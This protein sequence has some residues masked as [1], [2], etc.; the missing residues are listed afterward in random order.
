MLND[1]PAVIRKMNVDACEL[2]PSVAGSLL[3]KR[4]NA[5]GLRLLLTIGEMLTGPVVEEFGGSGERPSMLWGMYGPTE[6]AI[7]CTVQPAFAHDSTV[8]NIGVPLDTVSAFILRIPGRDNSNWAFEVLPRGEVG[9]LAIGGHQLA[10]GYLNRPD[11]TSSAFI[12]TPFGH[13]YRTGDKARMN[14]DGT[15]E[16]LGRIADGQVKLRGQRIELG[17]IEHAA[18]RTPGCHNAVAAVIEG[19]LV[20]FCAVDGTGDMASAIRESCRE[21]LPGFMVPGD[22]VVLSSFPRLPSGKID[23]KRLVA[24]YQAGASEV[25]QRTT[26]RDALE[27]QLC[28]LAGACLGAKVHP[29]QDLHRAGLDSLSAIKFASLLRKAG[30]EIGAIDVLGARTVSAL[31]S[32]LS[33]PMEAG[34]LTS[35]PGLVDSGWLNI[36]GVLEKHPMLSHLTEH[37]ESI[38]PCTPLQTSMLAE[39]MADPRAYCNWVELGFPSAYTESSIR[40]WFV[41]LAQANEILRTGFVH[42]EGKFLQVIFRTFNESRLSMTDAL[43]KEFEMR[44]D[45]DFLR[46]FRVQISSSPHGAET[47]VLVQLHHAVYDGWSMDLMLADLATTARGEQPKARAQFRAIS[48]YHQSAAFSDSC[49]AAREFWAGNLLDFQPPAFPVWNAEVPATSAVLSSSIFLDVDPQGLK[50][51]LQ[52]VDCTPQT[53]FQAA[54]A[55]LWSSAAGSE[56]VVIGSVTS[57]RT[58]PVTKIEDIIGPCIATVPIRTDLS[59]VRT[60]RD[61]LVSVHAANRAALPHSVLPLSEIKRVAGLHAG[62]SVYDVLFVYQ[63]SLPSRKRDPY[64]FRKVASQDHLETKLLVEVEPRAKDFDCRFTYHSDAFPVAQV[65]IF[66]EL[67]RA[68]IL[69]ILDNVDLEISSLRK[70]FPEHLLSVYNPNPRSFTGV[71]DLAYAV[72]RSAASFP[73]KDAVCFADRISDGV[74]KAITIT[75]AE[76]NTTADRIAWHLV[77]RG[78]REAGVVSIIMEKSVRFYA[79]VLA[80]LKAG[81]AYLP[82]LP[83]TPVARIDTIL[84]QTGCDLCL[85]DAATRDKLEGR[86]PCNFM[87]IESLDL[88]ST[89]ALSVKAKPDPGRLAYIIY[90]SGSTG[91]PKGVCVTQLNIMSNLD[92]LS[93]VYPVKEN[94]RLLQSCSQAF[95]VSV[96]EIFFAWTRGICLCSAIND[97]LF[98]N[99]ERSI[100]KLNITHLSMTPTVAS[101]VDPEKVPQVEFLVTAGEAMTEVVAKAWGEKLYQGYGPSE[102]TNICSVKKMGPNQVI[103]HLG[104]SFENTSTVVLAKDGLEIVPLGCLG[105]LCF[106]GDQVARGYLDMDDRTSAKFIN[107]STLGRIYRSGDLG[108]MLP[109]GSMVIAGRMDEQIK[110][111]GQR[112]ELNEITE[113]IRHSSAT[114]A[115][116]ATLFLREEETP[117]QDLIVAFLVPKQRE[118]TH[119]QV[120]DV[121][122]ELRG[123]IQSLYH[124]LSSQLPAYM[125]PSATIPISVLPTT[126]SGKLDR[127]RLQQTFRGLQKDFLASV[128]YGARLVT[129]EGQWSGDEI[130]VAEAVACALK[131]GREDVRRW[132]PLAALGLDSIS[133]IQVSKQLQSKLGK[134]IPISLILQNASVARMAKVLSDVDTPM[135]PQEEAPDLLPKELVGE[136]SKRLKRQGKQFSRILPCTPLQEAMLAASAGKGHKGQYLNR[137]LF[138]VNGDL[139]KLKA[140]WNA[141]CARHGGLR[142][143]FLATDDA[144]WPILQV[145]LDQ[146]QPFWHE[147][148]ASGLAIEDCISEH[149]HVVPDALEIMEPAISLATIAG[150]DNIYLSFVCHHALYDG[151]AIERL[152]Y[153]VEQHYSGSALP[154]APVYDHFLRESQKLP[155]STDGFWRQHLAGYEPK[156]VVHLSSDSSAARTCALTCELDIPLSRVKTTLRE[157]GV[158]LLALTQSAWAIALSCVFR[159]SDICFGNVVNGRSLPIEGSHELVAPCFNTIPIRIGLPRGH[160]NVDL[161]KA[162]Q[163]L[164]TELMQYQFTPLKR[165]QSQFSQHGAWRLFDTLLL[166]QQSPRPLDRAI[167]TVE[168]DEGEMDV[169][170]VCEVTP[171][172]HRDSVTVKLHTMESQPL[173]HGIVEL[174]FDLF[175]CAMRDCLQFPASHIASHDI[176]QGLAERLSRIQL[177]PPQSAVTKHQSNSTTESWTTTESSVRTVL[178]TLS[179]SNDERIRRNTTIYQLGLDSISAVQIASMLRQLGYQVVA[180]DVIDHPTCESLARYMDARLPGRRHTATCDLREFQAEVESQISA[181]HVSMDH[182]EAV[183]PCTP[184]QSSMM[185]QF[186]KSGGR[187]YFNYVS[188][189]LDESIST[190]KLVEA[191]QAVCLGHP[192][193]RTGIVSVEHNDWPFAMVQ[194]HSHMF[195]PT[196][197]SIPSE[198]AAT[199]DLETWRLRASRA[200]TNEPHKRLWS[201]AIVEAAGG[202]AMHLAIHHA[203][204]DAHSLQL[205]LEDLSKAVTG[206]QISRPIRMES[207]VADILDQISAATKSSGEFWK[208][209]ADK[210]VINGFPVMTPLRQASRDILTECIASSTPLTALEEAAARSGCTLQAV[211]QAAWTRILSAYLGEPSVVFGVVLSGRNTEETRSAVFPCITT[212]PVI[213]ANSSS[214]RS[215]LTHMLQYNAE[216]F[217][218]QHQPLTRVQQWLGCPDSRLFDTLLVYQKLDLDTPERR[219]WRIVD[220][221]ASVDYPV[222][223]EIEPSPGGRLRYSVTFFSDV[224]PKEQAGMLLGQFDAA[225]RHLALEPDGQEEDIFQHSPDLF[226]VLPPEAPEIPTIVEFLHDFVQLQAL[227]TPDATALQF[228]ERFDG[229]VPVGRTWTYRELDD[230]G[231]RVAQ[232]LLPHVK[233]GDIVAVCF[234][235]CPEA[236]F[237]ILGV[238]KAGCAFVALDPGAPRS[239]NEF[240]VDDSGALVLLTSTRNDV[241]ELAI[242]VPV[243]RVGEDSLTGVSA[244]R[245]DTRRDLRP[246]DVCYCLYTSGTTG[247]PKGCEITHENAVQ[248]MLAFQHIFEGRWQEDSRW[249]QFASLHFDVSVLEQYW[250]WSVGITLVAAPR[251]LILEDLAGTIFR[252]E[253][254]H[255]D[256]TPSLARLLHPD[257]VPSL[258]KGVFIT[259][260]EALK[261][262]ILDVW[263]SKGVIYNFYGPT[264][265]TIG[266]TVY[267]RVPATGRASN[268]GKQFINVGSYVLKPGTEQPVLRGGVG[269]LCVSGK[270][271]GKGYL[272]RDALTSDKFP[273]LRQFGERVYRTGDLVRVLHDGCFDFLGRADDQ[274]KLRGQRLEIGEINHAIRKGV[275][276]IKDVATLVVRNE[277]QQKDLLVSFI[278]AGHESRRSRPAGRL[279]VIE[280]PEASDLCRRARDACH[281]KLPGYMVPTYVLQLPFIPLSA[282]NKAEIRE[283]RSLFASLGQEKL[284]SL[285]SA[286]RKSRRT[287]GSTGEKIGRALE[288]MQAIDG[289][290]LT[291]E[292]SI[293]EL[294]IDSISVLRFSRMLKKEGFAHASPSVILQHPLI[295]DLSRALEAEK[296][297]SNPDSVAAARQ[298]VQACA[299]KHRSHVCREL[300][301]TADDIE[302]IAPC[303]PLQ[304]GILSRSTIDDAYFNTFRFMLESTVSTECLREAWQKAVDALPILRTKFVGTTDGFVQVALRGLSLP[305]TEIQLDAQTPIEGVVR[306]TQKSWIARNKGC[307]VQPLEAVLLHGEDPCGHQLVLHIFHGLYDA[308]SFRLVLDRVAAEYLALTVDAGQKTTSLLGPSFL[309]AL[310]H[311]PLQ[312]FSSSKPFWMDHLDGASFEHVSAHSLDAAVIT[313]RREV[314]FELL[315]PSRTALGVTHQALVQAA[316]VCVLARHLPADP[317]IGVIVSGRAIELDGAERVVGPLFNTLPFHARTS[318]PGE[319]VGT[320]W[321][322]LVQQ[323][324]DFNTRVLDFQHVPLRDIQKW[325]SAGRPL[326]DTLFSFQRES[327]TVIDDRNLWSVVDSAPNADYP[328][329]LEAVLGLDGCLRLLLVGQQGAYGSDKLSIMMSELEEVL[330]AMAENPEGL[331]W[332]CQSKAADRTIRGVVTNGVMDTARPS[333]FAWTNEALVIRNELAALADTAPE[334]VTETTPVFGL[335]LD[336]IDVIKLS[337]RLKQSGIEIKT[338]ELIKAQTITAI[339]QHLHAKALNAESRNGKLDD[340]QFEDGSREREISEI[341]S[342]LAEYVAGLGELGDGEIVLPATPLQE[343][344]MAEM[345]ESDFQ[346]YFNHDVLELAPSVDIDKLKDA[347]GAVIDGSPILRTRFLPV[348]HPSS[349]FAYCQVIG[350]KSSCYMTDVELDSMEELAKVCD[351]ATQRACKGAGRSDLLQLVFASVNGQRFMVLSISH[352]LYDGWSLSLMHHDV[353]AAYEGRYRPCVLGS[354]LSL[355]N[356]ILFPECQKASTFWPG[357]LKDVAAT[358][359]PEKDETCS[360]QDCAT[361]RAEVTSSLSASEVASFCKANV[362]TLQTLGQACWAALL[363]ARTGSL[364]VAFGVVLSCRDSEPL[365][366][367]AFPTMNT[368]A[369]RSVLHGSVSLWLRYMQDNMASISAYQHFPLREA[370]KLARTNGPP[371]NTL[372][373][374]QR[375]PPSDS[376]RGAEIFVQSVGGS[377]AVEYP[378]CVE[379]E[380]SENNLIWRVACNGR[381]T[382]CGG[383]LCILQD[384]DMVLAHLVHSPEADVVVFSGQEVSICGLPPTVL[385]T[386]DSTATMPIDGP[387]GGNNEAWTSV[388]ETIRDVLAEVAGVAPS[389]IRKSDNIYNLGLDSISA[390]KAGSLLRRKGIA[391]GFRDMLRAGSISDIARRV[392]DAQPLPLFSDATDDKDD[393]GEFTLP[394]DFDL[395][396]MLHELGIGRSAVEEVFP[397]SP[398]QVHMLSMWQNSRGEVF[399][400]WFRYTLSGRVD[401]SLIDAAWKALVAE[402]PILRTVFVSMNSRSIPILQVIVDP[403]AL[404]HSQVSVDSRVWD[405]RTKGPL[406]QPYSSLH[407][408][409]D[410]EDKWALRLKIHHA[411]YDATSL[412]AIMDR[413]AALCAQHSPAPASLTFNWRRLLAPNLSENNRA[414]REKFWAEYL[415]GA[416]SPPHCEEDGPQDSK[417][418][419]SVV[420]PAALQGISDVVEI[421]KTNGVSLQA[422]FFAAYAEFLARSAVEKGNRRPEREV[423]GIYLAN[424]AEISDPGAITYPFLRLVPLRAVLEEGA[425]LFD[426]ASEIQRDI[427]VISSPV[428]AEVGLWEIQDWTGTTVDTFVNFLGM[429]ST[430]DGAQGDVRLELAE[431]QTM[432]SNMASDEQHEYR[433]RPPRELASNPV[434]DAFPDAIDVEVSVKD[435]SMTVGVFGPSRRLNNGSEAVRIIEGIVEVLKRVV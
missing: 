54:L 160:R 236:Y 247:T 90:T 362:I 119:F 352:A 220:E 133:A 31:H 74:I 329:A 239:R 309:D 277:T 305:W 273:T 286:A 325:C 152:L 18:L 123:E 150:D 109:D 258:C 410:G 70:A 369:V 363:A 337:A 81:C 65:N 411:L 304:Q 346:L 169:P 365:Q 297:S 351:A 326:F 155:P 191:W 78:V 270:L 342:S 52:S 115:D 168:R 282:N 203:L 79:G 224:L 412:P 249:L 112:V 196:L 88:Q 4:E 299:H 29:D 218:Q 40:S 276:N 80:I 409:R 333:T 306:E 202:L 289:R 194:Y 378:V 171:E 157:L 408:E 189:Q 127:S 48:A 394:R 377:A 238:L 144:Q 177:R 103:R 340:Y 231:N 181:Q 285:S 20:L 101:L 338:S 226:S 310:C 108:R 263:G 26:Y 268:I 373:I 45:E 214:N 16:C 278:V 312:D 132:T 421:C 153:E 246:S 248:C 424:R 204:Y 156:L 308:N 92:V 34:P 124:A 205:M 293:F 10:E 407:A 392:R 371:F 44:K 24:E 427:H 210:V 146:W 176:P 125:V 59:R 216:L 379:M 143:C 158:T 105:E 99:L 250:S 72:E 174:I 396:A 9:E 190:V 68:L 183:L 111:R 370:Q 41:Q 140:S 71:P 237:S 97:T 383:A 417:P 321:A 110:L 21:W 280:S 294:G 401:V 87:E 15:L 284:M 3:R 240:I 212:L 106:G 233:A 217:K 279:E 1:L 184:L 164:N 374:H 192:I 63:E 387:T 335:G 381:H 51:T 197:T 255:I 423:F 91:A 434:R 391:I 172:T 76:L 43:V 33:S 261:Q 400:P 179:S 206:R 343:S 397:A 336:S 148:D 345:I 95:D 122:D 275:E 402:I 117:S 241:A 359:F 274:V 265:A 272:N 432:D 199:F 37:I 307:I 58:I 173:S 296:S 317:T 139:T 89:P 85:V 5:T 330:G 361:Q 398:M 243:L 7:H 393:V 6:A 314:A 244:D 313:S 23:R 221:S 46:P 230:N 193:L 386:R 187:D 145:V 415:A 8:C 229:D 113:I 251:D 56:D 100:R 161:M 53:V 232:M 17:E 339:L 2:T 22:I 138:R 130:Q 298:L 50:S 149:A 316:W 420:K 433:E 73:Y 334:S 98:E 252:L 426:V 300:W 195:T 435:G 350:K 11:Q 425:S 170:L 348:D 320:T 121:D 175:S 83:S 64:P 84:R 129:D 126:S 311:G 128:S 213:A 186:I 264:E 328:L 388:E 198:L 368:V 114:V 162:F 287:L 380:T 291:L 211:F 25:T 69:Y 66:K 318:A 349:N 390:I 167:W 49:E 356:D 405:S 256:L 159:S 32:R 19:T 262:E 36:S 419:V 303:S 242:S 47:T 323:C 375:Q 357:Y 283:L 395:D 39:T 389:N 344:M 354:Y 14:P 222:S 225:V 372:F 94:S 399:Y 331:A 322:S 180:S 403:S 165:I 422:L 135:P 185:A 384:L 38:V 267:P 62:R 104:W 12:D 360:D 209:Q 254:T 82:L 151:V 55:W 327:E 245:L 86:L 93:R 107:H 259:G 257:D 77:Q 131:V 429:P 319:T 188:F 290:H 13:L 301:V 142:T 234:D 382:P 347:W 271:V 219:P 147:Y 227:K 288:M 96:F 35:T 416:S 200:A 27:Q 324:H 302:Y 366:R 315:E 163:R 178:A 60:I 341:A 414:A 260:G 30:F 207:A 154:P 292:S 201:V 385:G 182:V 102:T 364:D 120:L 376:Q 235:K 430:D 116:C 418:R 166:L 367:L 269:E 223:I 118:T 353:Q 67:F 141:I 431:D 355:L 75:F 413:F 253:I 332:C 358:M 404:E 42:H 266:V 57:G 136:V 137:M 61:L 281:S 295:G 28:E 208:T 428:N 134:R 406:C 228:V 215:L